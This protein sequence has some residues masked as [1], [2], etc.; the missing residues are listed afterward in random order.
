MNWIDIFCLIFL[1]LFFCLGLWSGLLKSLFRIAAWAGGAVGAYFAY[2]WFG[3][4]IHANIQVENVTLK[5]FC[6]ILGFLIPFL[7]LLLLGRLL[8]YWIKSTSLGTAN[9]LLGGVLGILKA[10]ILCLL[11]LTLLHLLPLSGDLKKMRNEAVAYDAYRSLLKLANYESDADR[12]HD[13][14]VDKV[15]NTAQKATDSALQQTQ[16][17]TDNAL[18]KA[19]QNA[20]E[21]KENVVE[22]V[23]EKAHDLEKNGKKTLSQIPEK[24]FPENKK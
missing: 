8:T 1:V 4:F 16:K 18:K 6:F 2:D 23:S 11:L 5:V 22:S 9:R 14:I 15:K 10:T 20:L 12:L 3:T 19:E 21:A 17:A 24:V 7:L 13:S